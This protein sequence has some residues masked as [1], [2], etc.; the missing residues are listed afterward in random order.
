MLIYF[1]QIPFQPAPNCLPPPTSTAINHFQIYFH[2][3]WNSLFS[4]PLNKQNCEKGRPFISISSKALIKSAHLLN[5]IAGDPP[6]KEHYYNIF[7]SAKWN[8]LRLRAPLIDTAI[9][10]AWKRANCLRLTQ[11]KKRD[12]PRVVWKWRTLLT[13]TVRPDG[14][15]VFMVMGPA[16]RTRCREFFY[17]AP[18]ARS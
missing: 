6:P 17:A 2:S 7:E 12:E 18:A 16:T 5:L 3:K 13:S 4:L 1:V 8:N 10:I 14:P 15:F 11:I 9:R